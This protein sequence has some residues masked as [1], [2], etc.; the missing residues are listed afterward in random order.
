MSI[1]SQTLPI[2]PLRDIV[3]FPHRI[4]P[5]F[6]GR[7]KSVAALEAAMGSDKELFLVAQLD[8]AEDDPDRDQLYDLGV[9]AT[10][11][12]L[13]KLPDGTVR[14]LVEGVRRARLLSLGTS[15]EGHQV[16]EIEDV[17][18]LDAEG[19]EAQALMRSVIDQFDNYAKLNKRLPAETSMQLS[20][21]EDPSALADAVASNLSIKVADKQALLGE[22]HPSRRLEMVFAFMEGELG[23]LQ[24]EKKIR[25]RVKRQMEKTQREYYLNEQLKAIQRELGNE[26]EEGAD[27]LAELAQK[28]RKTRLS[29]EARTKANGELKKLKGMAPM[30]AEATV[31]RN[32]LD[33]LL[34]LPW[35]K[36]SKLKRDI[37]EA[38]AVLDEDHYG[39]EK[40]KDRIV[41]YLAVQART[42]RLKGPILC[43]VGPPGVGKT[44]LG[45]SIARAT[46]R[47]FV[48][49]SLGGVRDEAE[50]RGHRRTYIGSLPGKIMSNLKKAGTSNP[51]FLLDEIDKLGQD[52]RGDP[53]S[54]LLEVLD[55]EQ[56][57][58]FQDHYLELDYD[59]SDIMFV[60]TANSLD[61]PQ[62][63]LDRMEIIRLEGYTEDEKVE[64]ARRH[65]IPKQ[66]EAHGLTEGEL[67][68]ED[69]G[70]R[71]ILRHDTREDGVRTLE[72]ELAKVARKSLRQILEKKVESVTL[73]DQNIGEYLGV[74][75][76]R[77]GVGEEEDQVGAVTGL[78]WTEVG[79]ELLTIE[80]VTVPGKGLI[81]T[82]GKLGDVMQESIATAMS[83]VK[84]RSPSYGV[85]PSIFARKDIHVH[86]PEGAVPKDGPSAGIGMVTAM[87]STLTGIPVRR[88]IAMTGE[89][90]LRGRVLPIGGLK[91]KLLAALRGGITT[92]LI[93]AENEK[94]L[95][96]IPAS[97]KDALTIVPVAHV[98]EVLARAMATPLVP[99]EWTEADEHAVEALGTHGAGQGAPVRH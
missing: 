16:A 17:A 80:A 32:Y 49:Q 11:M 72:R 89:V 55:P 18:D 79:G 78:A 51:L 84:A 37:A 61:M 5:L 26:G 29:K 98:D 22:L 58:K 71:S 12:Q 10:A 41:E 42:N 90:T 96:D 95:A 69:S 54:A 77:Y 68:F 1:M 35:G 99:I 59:L 63:L 52:F 75:R 97:V 48:R 82:T 15:P 14:V 3:V 62:A 88:D 6:V 87:I 64:I 30:S 27:E 50:I 24:V 93:P 19:P 31:A 46:G 86:L 65:L 83:F 74:T 34:G 92:V 66:I 56:N 73:S 4:V 8:P 43:L 2:L 85:K 94:D 21:I 38:Q 25:S 20:E 60:T 57:A 33:V 7:E 91:E 67:T 39:L 70:L 28:I 81:K 76:Y 40:V 36:K 9:V 45:R 53:A 13:L 47:E 23:V 44:S